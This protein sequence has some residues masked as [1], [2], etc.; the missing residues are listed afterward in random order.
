[1]SK[2]RIVVLFFIVAIIAC[3]FGFIIY[4]YNVPQDSVVAIATPALSGITDSQ[5]ISTVTAQSTITPSA[6]VSSKPTQEAVISEPTVT[7]KPN[8]SHV[9]DS[10]SD[11]DSDSELS[12]IESSSL[13]IVFPT[14]IPTPTPYSTPVPE[15]TLSISEVRSVVLNEISDSED[16]WEEQLE[17]NTEWANDLLKRG[18]GRSSQGD[19]QRAERAVIDAA[20]DLLSSLKSAAQSASAVDE[21]YSIESQI[22]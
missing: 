10:D 22:P 11:S 17:L 3:C 21:L 15:P 5:I 6:S 16:Y 12:A 4:C 1:M 7:P 14:P 18:M 19:E 2:P 13:T 20:L 9:S 8:N